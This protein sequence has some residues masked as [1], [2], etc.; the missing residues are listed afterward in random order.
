MENGDEGDDWNDEDKEC[1][2]G[3]MEVTGDEEETG[4]GGRKKKM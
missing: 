3:S 4:E 2:Q 1:S